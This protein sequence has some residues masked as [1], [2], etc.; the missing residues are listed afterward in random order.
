MSW[1]LS[2]AVKQD[3][4]KLAKNLPPLSTGKRKRVFKR[5]AVLLKANPKKVTEGGKPLNP[6]QV[7]TVQE[8]ITVDHFKKLQETYVASG[9]EGVKAYIDA[10]N[11]HATKAV[12]KENK[13]RLPYYWLIAALLLIT[14]LYYFFKH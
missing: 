12:A 2:I 14:L 10:V 1:H 7:Y 6:N 4:E 8:L 3:L 9:W 13:K 5:G 11:A